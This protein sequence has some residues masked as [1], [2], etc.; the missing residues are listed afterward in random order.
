MNGII[1]AISQNDCEPSERHY[2]TAVIPPRNL[3]ENVLLLDCA[4]LPELLCRGRHSTN[5]GGR[6]DNERRT[7]WQNGVPVDSRYFILTYL[8]L[9]PLTH[10][11]SSG[12]TSLSCDPMSH[13]ADLGPSETTLAIAEKPPV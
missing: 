8:S 2:R 13:F 4:D 6:R 1:R 3:G 9:M 7:L 5:I 12:L 10:H 11:I